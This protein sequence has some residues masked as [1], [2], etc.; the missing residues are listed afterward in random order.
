M[1]R[2]FPALFSLFF[3]QAVTAEPLV[4]QA[5]KGDL[6]YTLMGSVHVGKPEFYPLPDIIESRFVA[7]D[8]L[9]VEADIIND[10]QLNIPK[11]KPS[12]DVIT[13]KQRA[14]L[15][16]IATEL[17]YQ[18]SLLLNMPPWQTAMVLQIAQTKKLQFHQMLGVDLHFL[19]RT[20]SLNLPVISLETVQEQIDLLANARDDGIELLDDTLLH[21]ELSKSFLPCMIEAWHLGDSE[22]MATIADDMS[23]T[24]DFERKI[25][26]DRN[27]NWIEMLTDSTQIQNGD[28]VVIVGALHLPGEEGLLTLLKNKG[29]TITQLNQGQKAGC[30]L[31]ELP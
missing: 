13:S 17:G 25:L 26:V 5:Q 16:E 19:S 14:Q 1:K 9:I 3:A 29:F 4:W 10:T 31:P 11:G 30:V 15:A 21:W 12:G 22:K 27:L 23:D 7:A 20:D 8:A 6:T 24:N 28:Y 2:F 18:D